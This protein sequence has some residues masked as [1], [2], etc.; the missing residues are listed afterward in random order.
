M[1]I[2]INIDAIRSRPLPFDHDEPR[3]PAK[4]SA[5]SSTSPTPRPG[6]SA[7]RSRREIQPAHPGDSSLAR[8]AAALAAREFEVAAHTAGPLTADGARRGLGARHRPSLR[9]EVGGDRRRRLAAARARPRSRR[10][11]PSSSAGGGLIVLGETEQDKYGTNL[12]DLLAPLRR[13]DRERDG[14]GLRAPPRRRALLGPRRARRPARRPRRRPAPTRS[15]ASTP[16]ASTA[17]ACSRPRTAPAVIARSQPTASVPNAPLAAVVAHGAGRVVVL[18]DSDL[19]GDD[20]IGDLDHEALWLNLVYWAAQPAF[21]AARRPAPTRPPPSDPAWTPAQGRGRGA[22]PDPVRRRLGRH[23]RARPREAAQPGR[24]DRRVGAG[25]EAALPAP[26]RLHRRA[27]RRPRSP[28]P[29]PAIA[30][31]DF[32]RSIE[33]F[34]P[35]R[36]RR[37]GI[38]HLVRLPDVQAERLPRH[39][40]RGARSSASRGPSGST[41]SSATRYDNA[42]FLPVTFVDHTAGYDSECA[43]LFPETFSTAERPV[44]LP[45]RRDL[46][47]PRGRALPPRLRRC[48]R[49]PAPQPA[50][51][52]RLPALARPSSRESAY[53]LW[54][55]IHDRTHMRGDLPFDPFMIRQRSPYWMYSLEELRCDLTAFA[56][57]GR[58]RARGLRLRPPRP[59]RDPLRP[60]LPLPDHRLA[61]AQLRRP[62]RPA[63]VR[64]PAP[65]GLSALDRQPADDRVGPARRGRR[66]AARARPGPLPLRHRPL[67]ARPVDR[68]PRPGRRVRRRRPRAR[69]GPPIGASCPRSRSR[70]SS[71]TWSA[72]TSSRSASSTPSWGRSSSRRSPD[73]A[74]ADL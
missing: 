45:L 25:A 11:R 15:P 60:P 54:D 37:D 58:A 33:A 71:S 38:E 8:A 61:G 22:A 10:S 23:R 41:S 1:T 43:V 53:M 27:R 50:A 59:V 26:A 68:R 74:T 24:G 42:K 17:P 2:E 9:P 63:A 14:P 47:R 21:A 44:R 29:T 73:G 32:D 65:R 64:L 52:R 19:F 69:S 67:E 66:P 56:S 35:E 55:L 49:D 16:P 72:T 40:L 46:L 30:K 31:P 51:R 7:P 70:S 4:P 13:P 39:L 3:L 48:R 57:R 28:G 20:C 5:C 12:N 62:R 18:A 36:D 34:R 6:R